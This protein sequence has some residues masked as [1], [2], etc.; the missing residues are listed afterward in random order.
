MSAT[1]GT[2]GKKDT[3]PCLYRAVLYSAVEDGTT[4]FCLTGLLTY[5]YSTEE[6]PNTFARPI[7]FYNTVWFLVYLVHG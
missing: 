6:L 4:R 2:A 1:P 5:E 3:E 7:A